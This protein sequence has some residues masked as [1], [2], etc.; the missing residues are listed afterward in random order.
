[1]RSATACLCLLLATSG[2]PLRLIE[3]AADLSRLAIGDSGPADFETPDGGVG[4][5]PEIS[6]VASD[7][8]GLVDPGSADVCLMV[9]DGVGASCATGLG[10]AARR[11]ARSLRA[12]SP[13][14]WLQ[15]FRC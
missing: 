1:M 2:T 5:E 12:V 13:F 6:V 8:R 4:D 10:P 14:A 15:S 3:A 7:D 11:S 9:L